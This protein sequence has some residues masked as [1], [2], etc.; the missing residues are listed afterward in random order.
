MILDLT[1]TLMNLDVLLD[2]SKLFAL[3]F[4]VLLICSCLALALLNFTL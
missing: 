2:S 3:L 4:E 1:A